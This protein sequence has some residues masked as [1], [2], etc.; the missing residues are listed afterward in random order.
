MYMHLVADVDKCISAVY[1]Y[2]YVGIGIC[3]SPCWLG[4]GEYAGLISSEK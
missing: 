2:V 3:V 1:A 4:G